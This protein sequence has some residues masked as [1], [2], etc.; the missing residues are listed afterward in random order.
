MVMRNGKL[1]TNTKL[2]LEGKTLI[3]ITRKF[4]NFKFGN[5]YPVT[6]HSRCLNNSPASF[7]ITDDEGDWYIVGDGD[8]GKMFK[9]LVESSRKVSVDPFANWNKRKDLYI[10]DAEDLKQKVEVAY[11]KWEDNGFSDEW[12]KKLENRWFPSSD[13]W[14]F[15]ELLKAKRETSDGVYADVLTEKQRRLNI[16]NKMIENFHL[17]AVAEDKAFEEAGIREGKVEYI[18]PICGNMAVAVRYNYKGS[19]SGLGSGCKTCGTSH[20]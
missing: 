9:V 4:G 3:S 2:S 6:V 7:R 8:V 12:I 14:D 15:I 20:S 16:A 1:H 13:V 17:V 11:K 19:I 10:E 18:C 5:H